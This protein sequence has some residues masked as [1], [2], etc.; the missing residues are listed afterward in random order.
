MKPALPVWKPAFLPVPQLLV[1][2]LLASFG[3]SGC[4]LEDPEPGIETE[5]IISLALEQEE[6]LADGVSRTRL[7][8]TL[9]P[10]SD[11]NQN[12]TFR[13]EFGQLTGAAANA[14]TQV[15]VAASGKTAETFLQPGTQVIEE[16]FVQAEVGGFIDTK[17]IRFARAFAEEMRITPSKTRISNDRIDFLE[18]TVDLF[19]AVGTPSDGAQVFFTTTSLDSAE[20]TAPPF[21]FLDTSTGT[22]RVSSANG[23]PGK[24]TLQ[25]RTNN[26]LG[27]EIIQEI[28]V[29]VFE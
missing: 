11:A 3:W 19:R 20:I 7:V 25:V 4:E 2:L 17:S 18:I 26:A 9:G 16:V 22:V 5:D 14:P 23:F 29:E 12:I 8:G 21:V 10:Q 13:T 15:T 27:G 24:S 28:E 1:L 6:V